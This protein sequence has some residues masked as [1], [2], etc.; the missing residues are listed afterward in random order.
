MNTLLAVLGFGFFELLIIVAAL[1]ALAFWVW[2]ILDCITQETDPTNK[3]AWLLVILIV[4]VIGAPLYFFVRKI[5]RG[6]HSTPP[7]AFH[8]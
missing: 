7:P 2:M 3:I 1:A 4:G 6:S 8:H 5:P